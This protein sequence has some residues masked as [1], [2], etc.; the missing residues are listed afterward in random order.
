VWESERAVMSEEADCK[1]L[2][3]KPGATDLAH[4]ALTHVVL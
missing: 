2:A 4:K 1:T 3:G